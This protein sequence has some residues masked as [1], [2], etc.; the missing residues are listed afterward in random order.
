[1]LK[2]ESSMTDLQGAYEAEVCAR[3]A[4]LAEQQEQEEAQ[5]Q[6]DGTLAWIRELQAAWAK[7]GNG[8]FRDS[9]QLL[10]ES[11][12]KLQEVMGEVLNRAPC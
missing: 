7:E 6:L 4:L 12:K 3:Q 5:R 9:F 11:V 8:S 10:M 2:L 1:M